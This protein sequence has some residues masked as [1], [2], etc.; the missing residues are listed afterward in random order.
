MNEWTGAAGFP[1]AIGVSVGAVRSPQ[2][3]LLHNHLHTYPMTSVCHRPGVA[4]WKC[5]LLGG[6]SKILLNSNFEEE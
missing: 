6:L 4:P 5:E 3:S 1:S 2:S